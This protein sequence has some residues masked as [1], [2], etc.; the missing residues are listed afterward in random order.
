MRRADRPAGT[1]WEP[2]GTMAATGSSHGPPSVASMVEITTGHNLDH[3]VK[4]V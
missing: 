2:G 1:P 3:M 4:L